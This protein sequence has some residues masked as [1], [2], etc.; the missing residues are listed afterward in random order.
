MRKRF[1]L[2]RWWDA[3]TEFLHLPQDP[4]F[5]LFLLLIGSVVALFTFAIIDTNIWA[6]KREIGA[7]F[8][9]DSAPV[10]NIGS[11]QGPSQVQGVMKTYSTK[12]R[13]VRTHNRVNRTHRLKILLRGILDMMAPGRDFTA[14]QLGYNG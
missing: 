13:T 1:F 4:F 8:I 2:A 10:T 3:T 9:K 12:P 5:Y 7:E 11:V 6:P 14:R